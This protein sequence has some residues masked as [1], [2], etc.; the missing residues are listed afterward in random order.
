[1]SISGKIKIQLYKPAMEQVLSHLPF[2]TEV[3]VVLGIVG[4]LILSIFISRKSLR[5][6]KSVDQEKLLLKQLLEGFGLEIPSEL[7]NLEP[8]VIKSI[9]AP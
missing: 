3:I 7:K 4:L 1:M 9:K 8:K 5:G 6:V 2:H